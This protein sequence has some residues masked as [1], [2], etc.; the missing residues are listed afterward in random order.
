[1]TK[2]NK[3]EARAKMSLERNEETATVVK[4][5]IE[6]DET[7]EPRESHRN[8]NDAEVLS[9]LQQ[10]FWG[11]FLLVPWIQWEG[12]N[13]NLEIGKDFWKYINSSLDFDT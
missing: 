9:V 1:M 13:P 5:E 7:K 2:K 12:R 6:E 10:S 11:F 3:E 8:Q 4:E